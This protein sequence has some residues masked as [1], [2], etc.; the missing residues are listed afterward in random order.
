MRALLTPYVDD[1]RIAFIELRNE[2]L[3]KRETEAWAKKMI[4]FI[5]TLMHGATPVTLSV[6]GRDPVRRLAVLKK[7][8]GRVQ[9]D[10]FDIHYFG[11]EGGATAF[12]TFARAKAIAAPTQLWIGETGYATLPNGSGYGGIPETTS[13]QESAQSRFLESVTWAAHADGL[14]PNGIWVL[15]DLVPAA[16][17]DHV[18]TENDPELHYGLFRLDGT[19]KPAAGIVRAAFDDTTPLD[20]DSGFEDAVP[21]PSGILV[22]AQWQMHGRNMVLTRDTTTAASGAASARLA[23]YGGGGTGSFSIVPP[24]GGVR[25]GV[26]VT[27]SAV[28]ERADPNGQ[29]FLVI[30]WH[31]SANRLLRRVASDQLAVTATTWTLLSVTGVAP[32]NAAYARIDLVAQN[33]AAPVWFDDV[34]FA[35]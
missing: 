15:N 22:P 25:A 24:D 35:R 23:P 7:G 4:P 9:P 27:A 14:P 30:E 5:R 26:R 12:D 17:P 21:G 3:P 34:S 32:R 13:A 6:A 28:A 11:G 2:I 16:V 20:F 19:P 31:D 8:L 18:A 1:P 33:V 10:F 29:V